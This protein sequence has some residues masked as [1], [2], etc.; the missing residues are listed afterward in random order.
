MRTRPFIVRTVSAPA[1][2]RGLGSLGALPPRPQ[3]LPGALSA[4]TSR[5]R[6]WWGGRRRGAQPPEQRDSGPVTHEIYGRR[7]GGRGC[8]FRLDV[9][10]GA[11]YGMPPT[12]LRGRGGLAPP[13]T[14]F[15]HTP[16]ECLNDVIPHYPGRCILLLQTGAGL[17]HRSAGCKFK[18]GASTGPGPADGLRGRLCGACLC[19][20]L[21][22]ASPPPSC[23]GPLFC[24]EPATRDSGPTRARGTAPRLRYLL[25]RRPCLRISQV[26][27]SAA[28]GQRGSAWMWGRPATPTRVRYARRGNGEGGDE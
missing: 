19:L 2:L 1:G 26:A 11:P 5:P 3:S 20:H 4:G 28:G 21:P 10:K 8:R 12:A 25:L 13:S 14:G 27:V 7:A 15:P 24:K 18:I 16:F 23:A 17:P 22:A 9:R 6:A